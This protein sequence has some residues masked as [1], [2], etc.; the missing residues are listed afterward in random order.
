MHR[1]TQFQTMEILILVDGRHI[2]NIVEW[3][4]QLS[5]FK[6]FSE[7]YDMD[8]DVTHSTR[9]NKRLSNDM[10]VSTDGSAY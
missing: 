9:S 7:S 1:P 2:R 3:A 10:S 5:P 8:A 6:R 4:R